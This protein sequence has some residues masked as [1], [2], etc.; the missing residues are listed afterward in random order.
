VEAE[1]LLERVGL[2]DKSDPL[3]ARLSGGRKQ[4]VGVARAWAMHPE[5]LLFD[6][7]ASAPD[8]ELVAEALSVM[9]DLWRDDMAMLIVAHEMGF[10]REAANR[11]M[12]IDLGK[13][14]DAA[15]PE[16]CF[17]APPTEL[18]RRSSPATPAR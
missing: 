5:L 4:R 18:A 3:P 16:N 13:P 9:E 14:V 12:F 6:E 17:T 8:P 15:V 2:G 1:A 10:A 11:I 7:P